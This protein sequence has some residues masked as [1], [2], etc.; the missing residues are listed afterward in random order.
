MD[1]NQ[2]AQLI[3]A[4]AAKSGPPVH[5]GEIAAAFAIIIPAIVAAWAS[6][7][8]KNKTDATGVVLDKVHIAVNSERTAMQATLKLL[9]ER[10]IELSKQN[11]TI[12][13]HLRGEQQTKETAAA[14]AVAKQ[15]VANV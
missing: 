12:Q 4:L 9:N 6:V 2:I 8:G 13:E 14:V 11:A 3:S 1:T 5:W 7:K 10:I 15:E